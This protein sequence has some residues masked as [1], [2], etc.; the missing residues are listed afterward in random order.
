[1][2]DAL[3]EILKL[4]LQEKI[5]AVETIWD[6]IAEEADKLPIPDWHKQILEERLQNYDPS[7]GRSWEEVKSSILKKK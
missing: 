1:M 3:Q 5:M 6:S 4:S 7:S 2:S